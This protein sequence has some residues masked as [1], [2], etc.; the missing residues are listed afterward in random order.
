MYPPY[1][2]HRVRVVSDFALAR[3]LVLSVSASYDSC[4]SGRE[5]ASGFL[6]IPCRQ[7]HPCLQLVVPTTMPTTVF[8]R[9]AQL[10]SK[11]HTNKKNS[12]PQFFLGH[13]DRSPINKKHLL[14]N[15]G[16]PRA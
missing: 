10:S 6:Q 1:L 15:K 11:T 5:F 4:S 16:T 2:L 14:L 9:L 7:G 8:H 12:E 13:Y 3:R